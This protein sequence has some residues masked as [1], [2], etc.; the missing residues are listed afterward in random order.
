MTFHRGR[1]RGRALLAVAAIALVVSTTAGAAPG[2]PVATDDFVTTTVGVAVTFN[3]LANDFDPGAGALH[4]AGLG[5]FTGA[6][7]LLEALSSDGLTGET[8]FWPRV[9][10]T[11]VF[12]F[13]YA[14][15]DEDGN[16]D[17][18]FVQVSVREVDVPTVTGDGAFDVEAGR[19]TH[20]EFNAAPS[21]G[22]VGGTFFLQ[23]FR[24]QNITFNGFVESLSGAG[25]DA[26]MTGTGTFNGASG[27]TFSVQLVEKGDPGGFKGDRIGVEIRNPGGTVVYTTNGTTAISNGNIQV[28]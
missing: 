26:T 11:G 25:P 3:P 15:A 28:L 12:G 19:R 8:T 18:A 17:K 2:D 24:G 16:M 1:G 6:D 20:F 10:Y 21:G 23:R 22:G 4:M 14:A 5:N 7:P 27:Y 13:Q 9:P